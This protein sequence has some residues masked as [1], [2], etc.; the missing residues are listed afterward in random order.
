MR[1]RTSFLTFLAVLAFGVGGLYLYDAARENV[2]AEGVAVSGVELGGLTP[3]EARTRL[4]RSLLGPMRRPVIVEAGGRRFA[5]SARQARVAVNVDAMVNQALDSSR[6][7]NLLTRSWRALTGEE[8]AQADLRSTVSFSRAAVDGLVD[9]VEA[10]VTRPAQDAAVVPTSIGLTTTA[11]RSGQAL[12]VGRLRRDVEAELTRPSGTRRVRARVRPVAPRVRVSELAARYSTYLT[13]SKDQTKLRLWRDLELEK[14]YDVA[15]GMPKWPTPN[16]LFS[17]Q[18]K[19][20]DP[21][22]SVPNESWAGSLA[23][24]VIPG[25]DP[26][27]PLKARWMGFSGGAGIHGTADVNSL[28]TAASH[29]CI[30]MLIADVVDLYDRVDVGTPIFVG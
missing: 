28:G 29:G 20:V 18:S 1:I 24:E 19:E 27:N 3:E 8:E 6:D 15:V 13:V 11:Q 14:T 2:V 25:G 7:G 4:K 30:R 12:G 23:G 17:I 21:A 16:G 22:W 9:R 10:D 26:E 5:L